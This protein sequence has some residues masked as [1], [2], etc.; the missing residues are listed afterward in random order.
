MK[1]IIPKSYLIIFSKNHISDLRND[2]FKKL[3]NNIYTV[4]D[5]NSQIHFRNKNIFKGLFT[6]FS[7]NCRKVDTYVA[8]K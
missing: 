4:S 6:R 8:N 2:L 5:L 3:K 1:L 7:L